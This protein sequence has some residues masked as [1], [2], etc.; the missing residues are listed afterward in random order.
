MIVVTA[1]HINR[2]TTL[3]RALSGVDMDR[4]KE[5]KARGI[6]IE[7]GYAY[8]PLN[9]RSAAVLGFID[10]PGH[11]KLVHTM[12]A[13][14]CGIDFALLVIAA[15]DGVMPQTREHLAILELLGV[16]QGAVAV[17]KTDRA[18]AA[19]VRE[20]HEQIEALLADS[21]LRAAP[22]FDTDA[23]QASDTSVAALNAHLHAAA[24]S[25]CRRCDDGFFRLA[26][27]RVFT[28]AG[29]AP[30]PP[31]GVRGARE[32]RHADARAQRLDRGCAARA[33]V[34]AYRR[35]THAACRCI[36]HPHALGAAARASRHD[37][38]RGAC[39]AARCRHDARR[40]VRTRAARVRSTGVRAAGR[41]LHRAQCAG[42]SHGRQ[43][44]RARSVRAR[45]QSPHGVP[46]SLLEHLLGGA[47][48]PDD[49][50][51]VSVSEDTLFIAAEHW[52]AM[53][54]RLADTLAAFYERYPDEQ[55]QDIAYLRRMA[56]PFAPD[57]LWCAL[58]DDAVSGGRIAKSGP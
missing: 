56:A 26:V 33:H 30:S 7:L 41:S 5:E 50:C 19:R 21:P 29:R 25:W 31:H 44:A 48:S 54:T 51:A 57:A 23:T 32:G 1:G 39:R 17:T 37:A 42:E 46:R 18:D 35:R 11:E 4:L 22:L 52:N 8:V 38:S 40:H 12:A 13:G 20:V 55:G 2:K 36:A 24:A 53:H 15:D 16:K 6:S 47:A 58:V 45:A 28:L 34:R 43:R 14:A 3:V 10:V 49:A 9:D 27:D